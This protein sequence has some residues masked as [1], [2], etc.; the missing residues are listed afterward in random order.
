MDTENKKA[1]ALAAKYITVRAE[2]AA[3]KARHEAEEKLLEDMM[4]DLASQ[5]MD[6][7]N[8]TG[9]SSIRTANGTIMRKTKTTYS[10]SDWGALYEVMTNY[11]APYLLIKRIS[12]TA[13]KDFLE[14]HPEAMPVGLNTNTSY[15]ISVRKPSVK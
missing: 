12:N 14:Q 13:M 11:K 7:C 4:D 9:A 15:E 8:E 10:T 3:L 1:D 5:M 2:L 6:I